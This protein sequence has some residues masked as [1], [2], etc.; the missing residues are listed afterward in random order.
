MREDAPITFLISHP[1][2]ISF[3][4]G[5]RFHS[6]WWYSSN[7]TLP[8]STRFIRPSF[9]VLPLPRSRSERVEEEEGKTFLSLYSF[10]FLLTL[11]RLLSVVVFVF[12]DYQ[13]ARIFIHPIPRHHHPL[14]TN[15]LFLS[16]CFCDE[17][18]TTRRSKNKTSDT[19]NARGP[20]FRS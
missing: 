8:E 4:G 19:Q 10:F 14:E 18:I 3:S 7:S 11:L 12:I 17:I 20:F 16:F 9:G 2:G 6:G 1:N 13:Q 15:Q 5:H